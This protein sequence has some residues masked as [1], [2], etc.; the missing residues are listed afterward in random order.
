[1]R[2]PYRFQEEPGTE[3]VLSVDGYFG[4]PGL[5]LSHWPGHETPEDLRHDL[6]TGSA[7]LFARL[8]E[9]ERAR[10]AEGCVAVVNNH[11]DTDG[12]CATYAVLYPEEA[13][14][15]E[16]ELLDAAAAG[17]FFQ[18]PSEQAFC[19][20]HLV[21]RW[22]E[23]ETS[24]IAARL[25]E[26]EDEAAERQLVIEDLLERLPGWLEGGY[27][28]HEEL[29]ASALERLGR[30][31]EALKAATRDDLVHFDLSIWTGKPEAEFEP[32][33]HALYRETDADRV[34]LLA[35]TA[36]GTRCRFIINTTSWF[37]MVTREQLERPD[38][39]ALCAHLQ[40][41][42]E[43]AG[44]EGRWHTHDTTNAAPE[45]WCGAPGQPSFDEHN[46]LLQPSR[47]SPE[48]LK[49]EVVEAL[50]AVWV[51]PE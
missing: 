34:L 26:C 5:N 44:G 28:E 16:A 46:G 43:A 18:V 10:R 33:R 36:L 49:H 9:E 32:G 37:D 22:R 30:D 4:A 42:E 20:D 8:D 41:L 31:V 24:P 51:F 25:A 23:P 3:P 35:P 17:D 47:L 21:S 6:S 12:L 45:L 40:E 38:L 50:R 15:R 39:G 7:L 19:I 14:S 29:Y 48:V 13:L 2:L 11:S 27:T 1:M